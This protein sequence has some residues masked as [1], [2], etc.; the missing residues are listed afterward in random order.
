MQDEVADASG[1]FSVGE[2]VRGP[3]L[4]ILRLTRPLERGGDII[5][6]LSG[7]LCQDEN[8]KPLLDVKPNFVGGSGVGSGS[9]RPNTSGAGDEVTG[10]ETLDS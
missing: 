8:G 9:L 10:P 4:E 7:R 6:Q 5:A 3:E 1:H 2:I